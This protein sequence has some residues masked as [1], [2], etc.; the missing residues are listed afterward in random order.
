[1]RSLTR[2]IVL[3]TFVAS[4]ACSTSSPTDAGTLDAA[5]ADAPKD[6]R[7]D[8]SA[9]AS[10]CAAPNVMCA[11]TCA[12]LQRNHSNCGACGRSCQAFERCVLGACVR[13][14]VCPAMGCMSHEECRACSAEGDPSNWCCSGRAGTR[15]GCGNNLGGACP[16]R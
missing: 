4:A 11:T 8:V 16:P 14:G 10:S 5:T 7:A 2:L 3:L 12:D 1:M 15:G 13:A 9:E 6:A